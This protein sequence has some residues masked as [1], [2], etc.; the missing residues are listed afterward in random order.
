MFLGSSPRDTIVV[1]PEKDSLDEDYDFFFGEEVQEDT[2]PKIHARDTM[3]VP[4]SLR[5]TNPFLYQWYVAV[6]DSFTH[7][8]VVDSLKAEGDSII[9]PVIDSLYLADSSAAAKARFDA[10]Y[11]SLS[12]AERRRYDYEQSLPGILHRQDSIMQRKDSLKRIRDS[13]I[14]NTPRI[15][16]TPFIPDSLYFRRLLAWTHNREFNEMKLQEWDTTF[17]YHFE[18]YPYMREDLGGS[19]LGVAGSPVQTYNFFKRENDRSSVSFYRAMESWTYTPGSIPMFNSKTPYTELEYYGTLLAT[20]SKESDN[21]RLFTTQNILP[22]LNIALEFKRYGGN[23]ILEHENTINKT[24]YVAGNWL[25]KRYLAH[26]G[27]IHNAINRQENG[28]I[29]DLTMIRD[30]T[31]E[32]REIAVVLADA[33]NKYKK[34]TL[35]LDQSLR[36]PFTFIEKLRHRK[37]STYVMPED[38]ES[39]VTTAFIGSSHE[40]T[41]WSKLYT[42]G[43]SSGNATADSFFGSHY[44][45]NPSKSADS[46]RVAQLDNKVFI[47]LQPW[48]EDFF[49]SRIEGGIG[50]R[51]R[52]H[53]MLGPGDYLRASGATKWNSVY[54]YAGAEG[55]INRYFQWNALGQYTFAGSE[56]NDFSLT[57]RGKL[58]LYPF[59]RHPDSPLSIGAKFEQT[60]LEPDFYEQNFFSNHYRWSNS[61]SKV[62]TTRIEASLDIPRW[63]LQASAGYALLANNI[64]YDTQG[65]ARQNTTPMSVASAYLRKEFVLAGDFIHLDNRF[66]LQYSSDQTV[67]PLPLLAANLRWFLQFPIVS[68]DVMKMQVGVNGH[69]NTAW[70]APSY[71]PVAGVFMAQD[72]YKYGNCPRFDVFL[73]MQWKTACIFV[74]LENV[75]QGW[76]M[77][78]HD[79]FS[80]ANYIHTTRAVKLGIYWPFHPPHNENKTLSSRASS[81]FGGGR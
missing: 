2:T 42:D 19:F 52:S 11:A 33:Q 49:I 60:L 31:I 41:T 17:N 25:G 37:D 7:R 27:F 75:G 35:F 68:E 50:D 55:M 81:G 1:D 73:N 34:N 13:I 24:S 67:L 47:R 6:K 8:T 79:Y 48:K 29:T 32:V 14:E 77:E 3:K 64:Y 43:V 22:S 45:I 70:Y 15:L 74:K 26:F 66:L 72:T 58:N 53:Y 36:I 4:D 44:Y 54:A 80:A 56:V 40:F 51:F 59:R 76:P 16:E 10:W 5:T 39:D 20:D 18:D 63:K 65:I 62:S 78:R 21:I 38:G 9:W 69:Y 12:K 46:L 57:A 71:N 23:G 30:T 61:F 28:G